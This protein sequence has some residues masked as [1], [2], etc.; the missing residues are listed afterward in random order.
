MFDLAPRPGE[1]YGAYLRRKSIQVNAGRTRP[2]RRETRDENGRIRREVTERTA[3]GA[4]AT[5]INRTDPRG[6][7]HQDVHIHAPVVTGVGTVVAP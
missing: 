5:T 1:T 4:L 3:S 2:R 6:G 7:E